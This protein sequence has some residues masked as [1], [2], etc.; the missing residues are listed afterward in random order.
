[1]SKKSIEEELVG[2]EKMI[3]QL[4]SQEI[5][6]E[7]SFQLY[8][9]GMKLVREINTRIDAVEAQVLRIETDREDG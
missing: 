5:S 9:Q 1:M 4:E 7:E 3:R 8:E 6:L 2:L